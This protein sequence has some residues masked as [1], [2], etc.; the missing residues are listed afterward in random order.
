[1]LQVLHESAKSITPCT[2]TRSG[3]RLNEAYKEA[4][5][6]YIRGKITYDEAIAL[7]KKDADKIIELY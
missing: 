6:D 4:M 2:T 1:M 7:F 5:R 3:V